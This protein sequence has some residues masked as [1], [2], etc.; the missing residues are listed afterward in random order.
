MRF[1]VCSTQLA[2]LH[3]PGVMFDGFGVGGLP[4][5]VCRG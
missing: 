1:L 5:P 3:V 4:V 2:T